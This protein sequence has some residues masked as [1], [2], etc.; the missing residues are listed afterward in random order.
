MNTTPLNRNTTPRQT[1]PGHGDPR[2]W[3]ARKSH[4][5]ANSTFFLWFFS[6]RV[7]RKTGCTGPYPRTFLKFK[8]VSKFQTHNHFHPLL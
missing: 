6:L 4:R 5:M 3:D 1:P 7:H 2:A 8:K